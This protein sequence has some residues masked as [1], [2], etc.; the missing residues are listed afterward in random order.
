MTAEVVTPTG[1][2]TGGY[3][4]PVGTSNP[5]VSPGANIAFQSKHS[6]S[7]TGGN[8]NDSFVATMDCALDYGSVG[9]ND[10]DNTVSATNGVDYK[11]V[12]SLG[13][14]TG[15]VSFN[16]M[17]E[18]HDTAFQNVSIGKTKFVSAIPNIPPAQKPRYVSDAQTSLSVS[19]GTLTSPTAKHDYKSFTV[20]QP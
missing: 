19:G 12:S 10:L 11:S 17:G 2:V 16:G 18:W 13:N 15:T 20:T 7:A 5:P 14:P 6:A 9:P 3:V 8:P 1:T 4:T